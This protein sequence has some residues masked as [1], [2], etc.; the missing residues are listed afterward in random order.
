MLTG[1]IISLVI[2][3]IIATAADDIEFNN[4]LISTTSIVGAIWAG[5][6]SYMKWQ[7]VGWA[8][9]HVICGWVYVIYYY[10]QYGN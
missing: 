3:L 8:I 9:W 6:L 1:I 2:V 5:I 10:I 7:S 4:T